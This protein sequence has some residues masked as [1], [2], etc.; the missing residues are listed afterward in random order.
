MTLL[1]GF[2]ALA[3]AHARVLVLGSMP[4]ERSLEARQY[5]A[6]PHNAFWRIMG[7][8]A[9]AGPELPYA[10]RCLQLVQRGIAVWDVLGAC[11]RPGSL[12][13][14]IDAAS[15]V[16]N[17]FAAFFA[18]QPCIRAVFCNGGTAHACY[19]RHVLPRLP[20]NAAA[21]PLVRLPSTSPAHAARSFDQ[22]LQS[23]RV[24]LEALAAR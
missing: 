21:L 2:P 19:R 17:D 18:A 3:D 20:A 12:D 11:R 16:V 13:A 24:V 9:L 7:E 1:R 22:K 15:I 8:L 23:W 14:D 6:H 4:G 10:Q 5:Y